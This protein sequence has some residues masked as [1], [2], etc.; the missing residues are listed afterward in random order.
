[1]DSIKDL[2]KNRKVVKTNTN[3][4]FLLSSE[5]A[6]ITN[7]DARRWLRQVK[8]DFTFMETKLAVFRDMVKNSPTP[9]RCRISLFLWLLKH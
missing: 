3:K 5:I 4:V 1:M 7:S 9:I 8:K 6:E 2:L